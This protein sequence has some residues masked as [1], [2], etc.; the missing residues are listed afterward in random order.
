LADF[1]KPKHKDTVCDLCSG[2][3]IVAVLMEKN[4]QPKKILAVEIQKEA[5][6][7]IEKTV[8]KS[9]LSNIT[10][11]CADLCD[12]NALPFHGEFDLVTCN[13]PYKLNNTGAKNESEAFSIARHEILCT[14]ED[15][16]RTAAKLLKPGGRLCLCN[17]PERL[18]DVIISMKKYLIEPKRLRFVS[19]N[20]QSAPWLFLIEGKKGSKPFLQVEKPFFIHGENGLSDELKKLYGKGENE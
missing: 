12:T 4:S 3:G 7:L 17:R 19:K 11:L 15:V 5:V 10:P 13:P 20:A 8:E 18:C 16:S 1:S 2:N 6:L 14:A 9:S